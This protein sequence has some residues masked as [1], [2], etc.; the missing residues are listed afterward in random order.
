MASDDLNLAKD[1]PENGE[2]ATEKGKSG[3]KKI[4]IIVAVVLLLGGGAA[5]FLMGDD[6]EAAEGGENTA[7]K[8]EEMEVDLDP[9]YFPLAPAFVVNYEHEGK[10]RYV[11]MEMQIMSYQQEAIDKV[12]A[13]MPAVRNS[14]IMLFGDQN[15]EDL[16]TAKGKENL[17]KAIKAKIHKVVRLKGDAKV[18]DVFFTAFVTQ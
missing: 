18:E 14:L 7:T 9:I 4:I 5:F 12:E 10:V 16:L 1:M 15:F 6:K 17:R 11:Q 8:K 3:M 13:N 2:E